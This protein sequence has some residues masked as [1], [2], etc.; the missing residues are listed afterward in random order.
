MT[1]YGHIPAEE[2]AQAHRQSAHEYAIATELGLAVYGAGA[3]SHGQH[4][5]VPPIRARCL[6]HKDD[7][8]DDSVDSHG[9]TENDTTPHVA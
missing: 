6:A 9:L 8:H 7:G 1:K 2:V 4:V 3:V 5:A